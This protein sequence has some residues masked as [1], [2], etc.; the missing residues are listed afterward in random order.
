MA[1]LTSVVVGHVFAQQTQDIRSTLS[2]TAKN[3]FDVF[4][5]RAK[6][7]VKLRDREKNK[8]P[9]LSDESKAEEIE[10][11]KQAFQKAVRAARSGA[12]QGDVFTLDIASYI[13]ATIKAEFRGKERAELRSTV[14]VES[15]AKGIPLRVNYTYPEDKEQIEMAPTLLLKLPQLP[16]ELRYRFAGRG[17]LLVDR[18]N[19][20]IIDYM[21]NALP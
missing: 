4:E 16:K 8:L 18:D 10:T 14:L 6:D 13:R 20:L 19:G 7:Y 5:Q 3:A 12:K 21:T 2:P 9:K 1:L 17:M 11:H 15:D